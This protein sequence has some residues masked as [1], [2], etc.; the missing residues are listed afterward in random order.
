MRGTNAR[1][2]PSDD[3]EDDEYVPAP[4]MTPVQKKALSPPL[5]APVQLHSSLR[6]TPVKNG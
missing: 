5:P 3:S 6:P 2:V 1:T 4:P